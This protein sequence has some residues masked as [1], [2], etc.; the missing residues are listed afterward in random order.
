M[1]SGLRNK[2]ISFHNVVLRAVIAANLV[3]IAV[4]V[5]IRVPV[6]AASI[7]AWCSDQVECSDAAAVLFAQVDIVLDRAAEQVRF[8]VLRWVHTGSLGENRPVVVW[9]RNSIAT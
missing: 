3:S 6:L 2:H 8:V 1:N 5:A 9:D 7:L 4:V